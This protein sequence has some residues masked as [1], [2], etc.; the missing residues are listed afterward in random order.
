MIK[1][2]HASTHDA[3]A[4]GSLLND[5]MV[6][7]ETLHSVLK[8]VYVSIHITQMCQCVNV[9]IQVLFDPILCKKY[10]FQRPLC[11]YH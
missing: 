5:C 1:R 8:P 11:H 4:L 7:S 10:P 9:Y 3:Y 6:H 2:T